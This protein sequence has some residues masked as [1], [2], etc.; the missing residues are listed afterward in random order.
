M[1]RKKIL[2]D[3]SNTP[4]PGPVFFLMRVQKNSSP[5]QVNPHSCWM[6]RNTRRLPVKDGKLF[7]EI[8]A[9]DADYTVDRTIQ[10]RRDLERLD[11]AGVPES[12]RIS[13]LT[14]LLKLRIETRFAN[15]ADGY[16]VIN[17]FALNR[18]R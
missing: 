16:G 15:L 5:Q 14:D 13:G 12:G 2:R 10:W 1:R 8:L 11:W 6:H 17:P 9:L 4:S 18:T 7:D 3:C